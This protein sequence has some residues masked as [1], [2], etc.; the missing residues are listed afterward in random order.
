[1]APGRTDCS[2]ASIVAGQNSV[3]LGFTPQPNNSSNY[4]FFLGF[5]TR[6]VPTRFSIKLAITP[7]NDLLNG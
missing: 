4:T 7:I 1:M 3:Y 6:W 5:L 2:L